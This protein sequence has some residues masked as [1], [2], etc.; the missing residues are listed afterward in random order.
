MDAITLKRIETAHPKLRAE[1]KQIYNEISQVLTGRAICRFSHVLRTFDEQTALYN[2]KPKVTNAKAGQSFHNYG[3]AVDIVLIIDGKEASWNTTADY[4]NDKIADWLEIVKIFNK[5][6]WQW[7]L[8][9]AKGKRY[10]LPHFQKTF[11]YSW[12]KLKELHD[13]KKVDAAGYVLI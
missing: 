13:A 3:L 10:D 8:F 5:Y 2:Q 6:G 12:Q 7:G 4:D 11:G 9:N 1:L